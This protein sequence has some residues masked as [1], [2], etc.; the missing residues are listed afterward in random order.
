MD[1]R[2]DV[3]TKMITG[4][5][6]ENTEAFWSM[7]SVNVLFVRFSSGLEKKQKI[8]LSASC[9]RKDN[10]ILWRSGALGSL[11]RELNS[12]RSL[13]FFTHQVLCSVVFVSFRL[14]RR[15]LDAAILEEVLTRRL[16]CLLYVAIYV[17]KSR[18]RQDTAKSRGGIDW[19]LAILGYCSC[20]DL[21][22]FVMI[23]GTSFS[24]I[25]HSARHYQQRHLPFEK[26]MTWPPSR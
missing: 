25:R 1:Q 20:E 15:L 12:L 8:L 22:H 19:D 4:D 3:L 7:P 16:S 14:V 18:A 5:L 6:V 11:A 26:R 24:P 17:C 9:G 13:G 10:V 23:N 2:A 21:C